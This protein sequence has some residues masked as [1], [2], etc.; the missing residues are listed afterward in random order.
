MQI[1]GNGPRHCEAL[2]HRSAACVGVPISALNAI[3][4]ANN[5]AELLV[6]ALIMIPSHISIGKFGCVWFLARLSRW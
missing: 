4:A 5:T 1:W 3:I 2:M 6:K